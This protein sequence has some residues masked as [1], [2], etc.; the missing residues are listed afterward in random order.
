[1]HKFTIHHLKSELVL[2]VGN[3]RHLSTF[4][5]LMYGNVSYVFSS[6]DEA[7]E[8]QLRSSEGGKMLSFED[9]PNHIK[10]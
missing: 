6:R 3:L 8:I 4:S 7:K 10:R 5:M 9:F 1:M 2:K